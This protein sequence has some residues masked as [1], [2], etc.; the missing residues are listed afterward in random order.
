MSIAGWVMMVVSWSVIC[1]LVWFTIRRTLKVKPRDLTAPL[2]IEARI[3]EEDA[4][5]EELGS[6]R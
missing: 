3:E 4:R 6:E 1:G 2:D 5:R